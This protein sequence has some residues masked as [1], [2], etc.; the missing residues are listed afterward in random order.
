MSYPFLDVRTNT[1]IPIPI[2]LYS[3]WWI[4]KSL[5]VHFPYCKLFDD[6]NF[7]PSSQY[8]NQSSDYSWIHQ[9]YDRAYL[10]LSNGVDWGTS[11]Q[12]QIWNY[13]V[14]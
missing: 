12:S 13:L 5:Y 10:A 2:F 1:S 3:N 14:I 9:E 6:L 8:L 7:D 11:E 4:T